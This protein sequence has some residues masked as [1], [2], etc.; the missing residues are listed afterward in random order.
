[1]HRSWNSWPHPRST[2]T[3]SPSSISQR[4]T[5]QLAS[6]SSRGTLAPSPASHSATETAAIRHLHLPA[7][8]LRLDCMECRIGGG[9]GTAA[10]FGGDGAVA[11][12][13]FEAARRVERSHGGCVGGGGGRAKRASN[14]CRR[15]HGEGI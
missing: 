10:L 4:Q 8:P 1:M 13:A 9:G 12:S 15:R 14:K 7:L 6:Q 11:A 2:W 5:A 3:R